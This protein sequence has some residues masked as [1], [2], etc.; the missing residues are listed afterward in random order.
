MR[1]RAPHGTSEIDTKKACL[2]VVQARTV[3]A[4]RGRH[5]LI[6]RAAVTEQNGANSNVAASRVAKHYY[7][8]RWTT[9]RARSSAVVHRLGSRMTSQGYDGHTLHSTAKRHPNRQVQPPKQTATFSV[10]CRNVGVPQEQ[11]QPIYPSCTGLLR[12]TSY[13]RPTAAAATVRASDPSRS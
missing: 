5:V 4:A 9:A 7:N 3:A 6:N 11:T 2:R 13:N 8:L 10:D 1:A 12:S